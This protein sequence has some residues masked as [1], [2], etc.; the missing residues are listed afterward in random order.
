[1]ILIKYRFPNYDFGSVP[2]S[3][4]KVY[5][6]LRAIIHQWQEQIQSNFKTTNKKNDSTKRY[7]ESKMGESKI[8]YDFY[9]HDKSLSQD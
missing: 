7:S 3:N 9:I 4:V 1:L 6:K 2:L 8:R 5:N